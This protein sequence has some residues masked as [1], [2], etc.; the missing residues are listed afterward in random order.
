MSI[1]NT[2]AVAAYFVILA[3]SVFGLLR[4]FTAVFSA[5]VRASVVRHPI[6]HAV[7]FIIAVVMLYDLLSTLSASK[8]QRPSPNHRAPGKA[9]VGLWLTIED[10][11]P[12]LPEPGR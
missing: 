6:A 8:G 9:A 12:G 5:Q 10:R 4:A 1:L 11:W 7:W 2:I 3:G